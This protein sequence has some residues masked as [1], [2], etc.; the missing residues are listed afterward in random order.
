MI[1]IADSGS[2]KTEWRGIDHHESQSCITKGIN[3][4]HQNTEE[5]LQIL[6]EDFSLDRSLIKKI[7]F[8]GAGCASKDK[9]L[10]VYN[11]LTN[12][13]QTE[14]IDIESDLMGA[15]RSLCGTQSGIACILGTGSNSCVYDGRNI[16]DNVS[17]LGY[18]LGDEGSGAV[19]GKKL[20]AD[21]LKGQFSKELTALFYKEHDTNPVQL[22]HNIYKK[23]WANRYMAQFAR[24]LWRHQ[25]WDEIDKFITNSFDEFIKR[26]L[27]QYNKVLQLK[28]NF[29]GS[30]AYY[31]DSILKKAL[32]KNGLK[33]GAITQSPMDGLQ[34]Y[35][36]LQ[37]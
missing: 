5:I 3:P 15:A 24:F 9:T 31:F 17:P 6:S 26:N 32:H 27:L 2:T 13:F 1:L 37:K 4:F 20:I 35:H 22:L 21:I 12:F 14:T 25:D 36:S 30:I 10:I 33:A 18:I 16:V 23:P 19:M 34:Q 29:T 8:Y 28:I 11:A 7:H